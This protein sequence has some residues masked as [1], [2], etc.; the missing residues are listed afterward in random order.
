MRVIY[1]NPLAVSIVLANIF[2]FFEFVVFALLGCLPMLAMQKGFSG[3]LKIAFACL[4][5]EKGDACEKIGCTL[6]S[7]FSSASIFVNG[8]NYVSISK[9]STR[10]INVKVGD[11]L[12]AEYTNYAIYPYN[13]ISQH[14]ETTASNGLDWSIP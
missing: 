9:N 7:Y 8:G 5:W 2:Q 10:V 4:G 11:A 14:R 12:R 13:G 3:R 6:Q 1:G